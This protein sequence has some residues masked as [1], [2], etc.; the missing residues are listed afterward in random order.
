[1]GM[2]QLIMLHC[3]QPA[4]YG[5]LQLCYFRVFVD[6]SPNLQLRYPIGTLVGRIYRCLDN[7]NSNEAE[8]L[9]QRG[10]DAFHF[11]STEYGTL[12]LSIDSLYFLKTPHFQSSNLVLHPRFFLVSPTSKAESE[13]FNDRDL[14]G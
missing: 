10:C 9:P 8:Y 4:Y 12:C 5:T 11:Q 3:D 2:F 13:I 1:M 14:Q 6:D 7:A